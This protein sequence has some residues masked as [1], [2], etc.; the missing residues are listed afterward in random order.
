MHVCRLLSIVRS[1]NRMFFRQT[2]VLTGRE[3]L[4][5]LGARVSS[6]DQ[7]LS[8]THFEIKVMVCSGDI[9]KR[10]EQP[11]R[12]CDAPLPHCAVIILS[13]RNNSPCSWNKRQHSDAKKDSLA[14]LICGVFQRVT[15]NGLGCRTGTL[16]RW[17]SCRVH[18]AKLILPT[19]IYTQSSII[20]HR[21]DH[22]CS[23]NNQNL[24]TP[25]VMKSL[26]TYVHLTSK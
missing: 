14:G 1:D 21:Y 9:Q 11:T 25:S 7:G 5:I 8:H 24:L 4:S 18:C 22:C 15:S 19:T 10:F 23:I 20:G 2:L 13:K 12:F 26:G 3:V 16:K 17:Q 6:V